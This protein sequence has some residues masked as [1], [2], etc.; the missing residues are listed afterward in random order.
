MF[1]AQ[2]VGIG[3]TTQ[4][5]ISLI[6]LPANPTMSVKLENNALSC[7]RTA[8]G[9]TSPVQERWDTYARNI[10]VSYIIKKK[11]SS[12]FQINGVVEVLPCYRKSKNR[13]WKKS[14]CFDKQAIHWDFADHLYLLMQLRC[15]QSKKTRQNTRDK[16]P[17]K[18]CIL[19]PGNRYEAAVCRDGKKKSKNEN[20]S[21]PCISFI[22]LKN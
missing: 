15:F 16:G 11:T 22:T 2:V 1:C 4:L 21:I 19:F 5:L 14:G 20:L 10:N 12:C 17:A 18:C 13:V 7:T 3:K 9:M 6:G 8:D